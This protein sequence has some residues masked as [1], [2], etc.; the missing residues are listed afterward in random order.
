MLVA[1]PVSVIQMLQLAWAA[2]G[3]ELAVQ[4]LDSQARRHQPA[5]QRVEPMLEALVE[6]VATVVEGGLTVQ[7]RIRPV[8]FPPFAMRPIRPPSHL[9]RQP[10]YTSIASGAANAA[11]QPCRRRARRTRNAL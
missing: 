6:L 4:H 7:R 5:P 10:A 3:R 11:A 9:A 2:E 8:L 1:A